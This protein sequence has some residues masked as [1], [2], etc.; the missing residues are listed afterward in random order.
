MAG[1]S[2]AAIPRL[3]LDDVRNAKHSWDWQ[4]NASSIASSDDEAPPSGLISPLASTS[5][6]SS[7][8][9]NDD[10]DSDVSSVLTD[11]SE[12]DVASLCSSSVGS[13]ESDP[14]RPFLHHFGAVNGGWASVLAVPRVLYA[15]QLVDA[16]QHAVHAF[17]P[18]PTRH[19]DTSDDNDADGQE[20]RPVFCLTQLHRFELPAMSSQTTP[21]V[22]TPYF[23]PHIAAAFPC[24]SHNEWYLSYADIQHL[25]DVYVRPRDA[26][27][28]LGAGRSQLARDMV[29]HGYH[30]VTAI[31]NDAKLLPC[32]EASL[33]PFL[34][35]VC[36]DAMQLTLAPASIDAV[37]AKAFF[38][39]LSASAQCAV[40]T[41]VLACLRPGGILFVVAFNNDNS[42]WAAPDVARLL[43][44]AAV[45]IDD[46][47]VGPI[48]GSPMDRSHACRARVWRTRASMDDISHRATCDAASTLAARYEWRLRAFERQLQAE[49]ALHDDVLCVELPRMMDEDF[50]SL[51]VRQEAR[52]RN[53]DDDIARAQLVLM[54]KPI[55]EHATSCASHASPSAR[56]IILE[57]PMSA[58]RVPSI[59]SIQATRP[60]M[61]AYPEAVIATPSG[62]HQETAMPCTALPSHW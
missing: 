18:K 45:C 41:Q 53:N 5:S 38:E 13:I 31:D 33:A 58:L 37:L 54:E 40:L 42:W 19:K 34:H 7:L 48:V 44:R 52:S 14:V 29:L 15:H 28:D 36:M 61:Q 49:E 17:P 10:G 25:L 47:P 3:F 50:R 21:E 43:A 24:K 30:N 32:V 51:L 46:Q 55:D 23:A 4:S 9:S 35:V 12:N 39:M 62:L 26:V 6:L 16:S 60:D 57:P 1:V 27:V 22:G 8:S 59:D 20:L 56:T 2:V 11:A